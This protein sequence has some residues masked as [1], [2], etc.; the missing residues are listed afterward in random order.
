MLTA[1]IILSLLFDQPHVSVQVSG[2]QAPGYFL[3]SGLRA[4]S[5]GMVDN[6][7]YVVNAVPAGP[8]TNLQP[9]PYGGFSFFDGQL[10]GYVVVD[11][12]LRPTD[13]VRATE[14]FITDFHEGYQT[15][16]RGFILLAKE[17]RSMDLSK[18]VEGGDENAQVIG[19][20]IQEFDAR[21]RKTFEWRSIDHVPVTE[22]TFDIDITQKNIDYIHANAVIIDSVGNFLLSC[23]NTDQII[24]IDRKTG[25]II[26]RLGG[27]ASRRNDFKYTNDALEGSFGFSHQ[28]SP[29]ITRE[30]EL[31]L[32]DN[33]VQRSDPSSRAVA[34]RIDEKSMTVT[35]T[36]EYVSSESCY[37]PT[38]GSVQQLPNGNILVGWGSNSGGLVATEVD[39]TGRIHAEL[40]S[41]EQNDYPYRVYKASIVMVG[42]TRVIDA[43]K[44]YAFADRRGTTK[45]IVSADRFSAKESVTIERHEYEAHDQSFVTIGPCEEIPERW[46]IGI[47]AS[48]AN[49]YSMMID[50]TGTIGAVDPSAVGVFHRQR[51]GTGP[52]TRIASTQGPL[53]ASITV[54]SVSAG[55]YVIGTMLCSQPALIE[56]QDNE[57]AVGSLVRLEWTKAIRAQGYELELSTST[58]FVE[59]VI[60]MRTDHTD[61]VL[62]DLRPNT[63]YYWHVRTIRGPVIEPWTDTW[64][65]RV[66]DVTSTKD[67]LSLQELTIGTR[68]FAYDLLGK[69]VGEMTVERVNQSLFTGLAER[70]VLILAVTPDG[71]STRGIFF[72]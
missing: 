2:A 6:S 12:D 47:P 16:A 55:E 53:R 9:T 22:S 27:F 34:Y 1:L 43:K 54:P 65:F 41:L 30:G 28:H 42:I 70:V 29:I 7:G 35:K 39:R 17:T 3:V 25:A 59:E 21:G 58:D 61:T 32:F 69:L 51:E 24:K 68:V 14:P 20:V 71:R 38:M 13:T 10:G 23:R 49:S 8:N 4:D 33:G 11:A 64:S 72:P 62:R 46:V 18:L 36:W 48:S 67:T 19:A 37:A 31:L 50:L 66:N 15:M 26:W 45:V 60:L 52:L 57:E 5:V 63:T 44:D 56:P 40:R